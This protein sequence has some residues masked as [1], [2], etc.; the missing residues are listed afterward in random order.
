MCGLSLFSSNVA[1]YLRT[2]ISLGA[3]VA[4][5]SSVVVCMLLVISIAHLRMNGLKSWASQM[6]RAG[7]L[8]MS[9]WRIYRCFL[10]SVLSE[11]LSQSCYLGGLVDMPLTNFPK[12]YNCIVDMN[13]VYLSCA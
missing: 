10:L 1:L 13:C 2:S 5:L 3:Q 4:L 8:M 6:A 11:P 7:G 12:V 9:M